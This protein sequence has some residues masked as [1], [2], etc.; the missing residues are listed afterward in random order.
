[1]SE[2]ASV[3]YTYK[4]SKQLSIDLYDESV[5]LHGKLPNDNEIMISMTEYALI[6]PNLDVTGTWPKSFPLFGI[7]ISGIHQL[8]DSEIKLYTTQ[9]LKELTVKESKEV[10]IY[11]NDREAFM[12]SLLNT[13]NITSSDVYQDAFETRLQN[14][15]IALISTLTTSLLLIGF[16]MVGFYFVIRS[17]LIS[18]IYEVSVHRALGVKKKDIFRSFAIEIFTIS[19]IS[20]L[21]GYLIATYALNKLQDGLLGTLDFFLVTPITIIMGIVI[22]YILNMLAG[23]FPVV[24]LLRKTPAQILSQYDI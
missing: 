2:V 22:L 12:E 14:Q 21:I 5:V 13:F 4:D 20:T 1:M 3:Y 7:S 18:R 17:S 11:S 15:R 6:D 24:M 8:E 23:L 19:T 9:G 16:S 10:F